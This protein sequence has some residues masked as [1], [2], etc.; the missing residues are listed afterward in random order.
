MKY[1]IIQTVILTLA[2]SIA[3]NAQDNIFLG[4]TD[5]DWSKASNW[6]TGQVPP[7]YIIQKII[8][9]ADCV[10]PASDTTN[11]T[12]AKG[13]TLEI[14]KGITLTNKGSGTW[15][16]DGTYN[17][18]GNY[19]GNLS[20]NGFIEAGTINSSWACG[21]PV[22]YDGQ[23]YATIKI[24]NQCWMAENLNIGK[25]ING[26]LSQTDNKIIEKY[27]YNNDESKCDTYG[28]LYLWREM[29]QY[30]EIESTQG[31]CPSGWHIPDRKEWKTLIK[32]ITGKDSVQQNTGS[33]MAGEADLWDNGKLKKNSKFGT[34]GFDLIPAGALLYAGSN[35]AEYTDEGVES[36]T[37]SST[38]FLD[39]NDGFVPLG[40]SVYHNDTKIF[41]TLGYFDLAISVRCVK[42]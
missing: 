31:V 18:K 21:D 38:L 23:P 22:I 16:M 20:V 15:T 25:K 40:L 28:G 41:E 29:M 35:V 10:I 1:T 42:N 5:N 9:A 24:G 14:Q 7:S 4:T 12:F 17:A 37:W 36:D 39:I 32:T 27:C 2:I 19:V 13:S 34:S 6:S 3:L 33:K 8:I 26:N 11:Y 30:Y